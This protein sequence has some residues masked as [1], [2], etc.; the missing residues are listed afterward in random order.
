MY[1]DVFETKFMDTTDKMYTAEGQRKL[2]E[3]EVWNLLF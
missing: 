3:L 2:Q 1:T